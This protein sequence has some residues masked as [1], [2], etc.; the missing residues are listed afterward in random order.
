MS[1][2]KEEDD[3]G[4]NRALATFTSVCESLLQDSEARI[5]PNTRLHESTSPDNFEADKCAVRPQ[6]C[7]LKL[8]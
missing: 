5:Q 7:L 2:I 6:K 3:S 4:S 1:I 8:I